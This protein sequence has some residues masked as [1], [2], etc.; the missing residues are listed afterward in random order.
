MLGRAWGL[1]VRTHCTKKPVVAHRRILAGRGWYEMSPT[2]Q[3]I[4]WST[5]LAV[6][7]AAAVVSVGQELP[8]VE[9]TVDQGSDPGKLG[10]R[11][12][13]CRRRGFPSV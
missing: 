8:Y 5:A 7:S 9:G 11:L 12:S 3:V 2:D 10:R 1:A 6:V 4:S 13:R